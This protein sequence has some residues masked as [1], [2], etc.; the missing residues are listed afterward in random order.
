MPATQKRDPLTPQQW[1]AIHRAQK[2]DDFKAIVAHLKAAVEMLAASDLDQ[3][4]ILSVFGNAGI[5]VFPTIVMDIF[6]IRAI[7]HGR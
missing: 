4:E 7:K 6:S 2:A 5:P 1:G 3:N